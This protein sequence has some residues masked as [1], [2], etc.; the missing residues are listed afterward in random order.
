MII[1]IHAFENIIWD[2]LGMYRILKA[3]WQAVS[4]ASVDFPPDCFETWYKATGRQVDVPEVKHVW[5]SDFDLSQAKQLRML[6][7]LLSEQGD[8]W[9]KSRSATQARMR[10]L[11]VFWPLQMQLPALERVEIA[12]QAKHFHL[13][14]TSEGHTKVWWRIR[15]R[16]SHWIFLGPWYAH[17]FIAGSIQ[18]MRSLVYTR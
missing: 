8:L 14:G 6:R 4:Y 18:T 12:L 3:P 17:R 1:P 13:L 5:C 16:W 15:P 11:W 10:E 9:I 2:V 7:A